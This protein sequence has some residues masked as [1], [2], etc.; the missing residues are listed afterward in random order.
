MAIEADT[1]AHPMDTLDPETSR[2]PQLGYKALRDTAAVVHLDGVGH[3]VSTRA[4]V[5]QVLHDPGVFSSKVPIGSLGTE[6]PLIPLN[7][8]PPDHRMY[9][10]LLDPLFAPQR[11]KLLEQPV[12]ALVN[13]L[14]DGFGQSA[15]IDFA[16]QFSIPFPSEVFL[17]FW[18]SRLRSFPACSR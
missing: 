7:I 10:K 9:R 12:T 6:R 15:E 1:G 4:A 13:E 8:D 11:M 5:D 3:L 17:T 18:A 2:H 14:I 16:K